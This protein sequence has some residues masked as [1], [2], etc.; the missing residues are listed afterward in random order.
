MSRLLQIGDLP[1]AVDLRTDL[2]PP[3]TRASLP[4]GMTM[5]RRSRGEPLRATQPIDTRILQ[6]LLDLTAGRP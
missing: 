2:Q 1:S 5:P 4:P 3:P 6:D